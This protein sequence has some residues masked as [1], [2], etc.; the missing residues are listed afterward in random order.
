MRLILTRC[1]LFVASIPI[2]FPHLIDSYEELIPC[3]HKIK[4]H[5]MGFMLGHHRVSREYND[6]EIYTS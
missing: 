3:V 6:D 5:L 2:P 4:M 1:A